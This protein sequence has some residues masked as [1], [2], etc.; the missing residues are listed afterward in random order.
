MNYKKWIII[1]ILIIAVTVTG[2]I[3]YK[4]CNNNNKWDGGSSYDTY[5]MA[6]NMNEKCP[7]TFYIYGND[8]EFDQTI[9]KVNVNTLEG[10]ADNSE[11][12][13]NMIIVNDLSD[14]IML[15]D[16]EKEYLEKFAR[17]DKC[18]FL[19]LGRQYGE[20]WYEDKE[21]IL[22]VEH[23]LSYGYHMYKNKL[24]TGI[25][26]I[27]EGDLEEYKTNK[28]G[29]GRDVLCSMELYLEERGVFDE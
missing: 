29:L 27:K 4:N 12:E 9:N 10:C 21:N 13:Y 5:Y 24:R 25:G 20:Y 26:V 6:K 7:T 8:I 11:T 1:A 16:E 3:V 19:Y 15:S 18:Y 2:F 17:Q 14:E 28:Y 23:N 22:Q